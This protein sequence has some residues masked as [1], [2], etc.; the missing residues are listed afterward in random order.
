M[1]FRM[2]NDK[3]MSLKEY[4]IALLKGR[5]KYREFTVFEQVSFKVEKGE[6]VGIIGKNG[7]GKSTLLK[8][9][10]GVLTPTEGEV[11]SDGTI[12]PMLELGSGFDMELSGRENIFLNGS[13]L[14]YRKEFLEEK[15]EEI[16]EFS[17]LQEF[18]DMPIRNYSSGMLMRLAFSIATIVKPEVLIVD[19]ILAVGDEAFQKKS[20][21]KMLELMSGG[22][23]VLF[24]SHSI[25][26]IREMCNKVIWLE[27]GKVNMIGEAKK[28]CDAYQEFMNP[29]SQIE[30]HTLKITKT[31]DAEK[32]YMDVLFIYGDLQ[33]DYEWRVHNQKEQ[34][35]A[36]NIT[37][38]EVYYEDFTEKLLVN[39]RIYLF[40]GCPDTDKMREI[41][42]KLK[43]NNKVVLF[44]CRSS[45]ELKQ[46]SFILN[47]KSQIDGIIAA[48][49][50]I[51]RYAEN[52]GFLVYLNKDVC[53]DRI[54]QL[55]EWAVYDRDILP[56][57]DVKNMSGDMEVV[58]YYRAV[59]KKE[60]KKSK[61]L[62]MAYFG[63]ETKGLNELL[64]IIDNNQ[65]NIELYLNIDLKE[66]EWNKGRTYIRYPENMERENL[67]RLYADMDI[68][69][70]IIEEEDS[71][72]QAYQEYIYA[73]LV[74]VP[75]FIWN[76]RD[77][78]E[79][80]K[81][82]LCV[83]TA[84]QFY[85]NM[86][87]VYEKGE[88][89]ETAENNLLEV[90]KKVSAFY[91][92][93]KF[94][95]WITQRKNKQVVFLM[96]EKLTE[97][98]RTKIIVCAK[99]CKKI[100][101]DTLLLLEDEIDHSN[102]VEDIPYM[103]KNEIYIYGSF[104]IVVAT[105]WE[106]CEFLQT[107][108]SIKERIFLEQREQMESYSSGDYK[109]FQM[110]QSYHPCVKIKFL[111]NMKFYHNYKEYFERRFVRCIEDDEKQWY[112]EILN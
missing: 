44:D 3:I 45:S 15:Y 71:E 16:L 87:R 84:E 56:Y 64:E 6:V 21:R 26:Q 68:I 2:A 104:D 100:G 77:N 37:S 32:Y 69:I 107:Y 38:S 11:I 47:I 14:G 5:L 105:S 79:N 97:E 65:E 22:T 41:I 9:I 58:N 85:S 19:E 73:S 13:I 29:K 49:E 109:R 52:Q 99:E 34:L 8:I 53:S 61:K 17:E 23:T 96:K 33:D 28:V 98:Q 30:H 43:K 110:M 50:T 83:K 7:A 106:D 4:V 111:L 35:L 60:E 40:V 36:A 76:R 59:K 88:W 112:K 103:I 63:K 101:V 90:K 31:I 10:A 93:S 55:S 108:S 74:K 72:R 86:F 27:N 12:V 80:L 54:E 89:K 102:T 66:K 25:D 81:E 57:L 46:D 62:Q 78:K 42:Q 70:S 18:I 48:T 67:P 95:L 1:R 91:T 20:K 24:V 39:Y 94:A 51:R 75:I 82:E 92:G